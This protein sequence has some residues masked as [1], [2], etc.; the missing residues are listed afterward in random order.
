MSQNPNCDGNNCILPGGEVRVLPY[1]CDG[2]NLI[3]CSNCFR[4]EIKWRKERNKDLM[5]E[6]QF[7]LPEWDCL[8]VY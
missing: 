3:L 8:K 2:G 5:K 4:R 7:D 6:A 1:S